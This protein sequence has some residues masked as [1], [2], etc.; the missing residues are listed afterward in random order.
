MNKR[1]ILFNLEEAH[2]SIGKMIGSLRAD[3]EYDYGN[4]WVELQHVYQHINTAWNARDSTHEQAMA[5]SQEDF[6]RWGLYPTDLP[7]L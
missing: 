1:F 6:D 7:P 4:Y 5:C 3:P 2:E